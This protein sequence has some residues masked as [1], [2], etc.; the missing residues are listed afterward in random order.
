MVYS[1]HYRHCCSGCRHADGHSERCNSW[2]A[3][4]PQ[5]KRRRRGAHGAGGST[6]GCPNSAATPA[7]ASV[8]FHR[9]IRAADLAHFTAIPDS[10]RRAVNSAWEIRDMLPQPAREQ[11]LEAVVCHVSPRQDAWVS[12][13]HFAAADIECIKDAVHRGSVSSEN[14][15]GILSW[16][17]QSVCVC[18]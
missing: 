13:C 17:Q 14:V 15:A 5:A 10:V 3:G 4:E 6:G 16:L 11:L 8:E 7:D 9:G 12:P 18:V 1:T 2:Q